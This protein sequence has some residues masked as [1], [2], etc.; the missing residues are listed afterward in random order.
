MSWAEDKTKS[1]RE[2]SMP[3][4]VYDRSKTKS[5]AKKT[6]APKVAKKTTKKKVAA[7]K[8]SK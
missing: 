2:A 8:E 6:A 1:E 3:R 5:K 4:G 7:K